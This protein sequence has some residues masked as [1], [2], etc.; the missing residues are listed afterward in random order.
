MLRLKPS[1]YFGGIVY[2]KVRAVRQFHSGFAPCSSLV[3]HARH[4][5]ACNM[6]GSR[7]RVVE[8]LA[9]EKQVDVCEGGPVAVVPPPT[10]AHQLVHVART[11]RR[12]GHALELAVVG[13][14]V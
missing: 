1:G 4:L 7:G 6:P 9:L 13:L 10:L 8:G 11:A 2:V 3:A 12:A 14:Q 5:G